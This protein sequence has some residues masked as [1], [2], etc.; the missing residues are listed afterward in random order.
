MRCMGKQM[1]RCEALGGPTRGLRRGRQFFPTAWVRDTWTAGRSNSAAAA[2]RYLLA[3]LPSLPPLPSIALFF[4]FSGKSKLHP[5]IHSCQAIVGRIQPL[6]DFDAMLMKDPVKDLQGRS[7][8]RTVPSQR[9]FLCPSSPSGSYPPGPGPGE[10][11]A[12][13]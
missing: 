7:V 3:S 2:F 11:R 12:R 4:F 5:T 6:W 1:K 10:P 9:A 13:G 8:P